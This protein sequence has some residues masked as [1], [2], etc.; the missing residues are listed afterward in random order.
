MQIKCTVS[1]RLPVVT[2]TT[3]GY[4]KVT[5]KNYRIRIDLPGRLLRNLICNCAAFP[6]IHH[7]GAEFQSSSSSDAPSIRAVQCNAASV[8]MAKKPKPRLKDPFVGVWKNNRAPRRK[9][10]FRNYEKD[11]AS[12][13]MFEYFGIDAAA[14]NAKKELSSI[15]VLQEICK[16]GGLP[17]PHYE[18]QVQGNPNKPFHSYSVNF[19]IP[20]IL[21]STYNIRQTHVMG[22]ARYEQKKPAKEQAAENVVMKLERMMKMEQF[23]MPQWLQTFKEQRQ[24]EIEILQA[25]PV[26]QQVPGVA[27]QNV[28]IDLTFQETEPAGRSGRISFHP[29]VIQHPRAFTAA[30]ILT[31]RSTDTLPAIVFKENPTLEGPLQQWANIITDGSLIGVK[32]HWLKESIGIGRVGAEIIALRKAF[33]VNRLNKDLRF[34]GKSGQSSF[35]MAKLFLLWPKY[36]F[37]ALKELLDQV[38]VNSQKNDASIRNGPSGITTRQNKLVTPANDTTTWKTRVDIFRKHQQMLPL[39]IDHVESK[40][41]HEAWVTIVRGGTASG[42]TTR[43]PL[44]LSLFSPTGPSTRVLVAQPRRLACQTAARRV[45]FEQDA[46]LGS[47]HCPVGYAI[48]F[49]SM[50]SKAHGR[51]IDFQTPGVILRKAMDDPLLSD[52]THLCID[53]VHERNADM[54]LLVSLAKETCKKRINHETLPPLRIILMSATLDSSRWESYFRDAFDDSI[55]SVQVLDVPE[56]RRFPVDVVHLDDELFPTDDERVMNMIPQMEQV[57]KQA[58]DSTVGRYD[59]A[60]CHAMAQLATYLVEKKNLDGGSILCFLPGMDEIRLVDKMIQENFKDRQSEMPLVTYLHS[61]LYSTDQLKVFE[62]GSK[63]ILST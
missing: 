47:E 48:R 36:Q 7:G 52:I 27:W 63:I 21:K 20:E 43:Y 50:P 26:T 41:P 35:G 34:P 22:Q 61:S 33:S 11:R 29:E 44:L 24:R 45:A 23:T 58:D 55:E 32:D 12:R 51:T 46:V 18:Y 15:T 25:T 49:A 16:I 30:K 17:T 6:K 2:A 39:P 57:A 3:S 56:I 9:K 1:V 14:E 19:R 31:A 5:G 40:I 4:F 42:K 60:L 59:Q 38:K 10:P 53:E 13:E 37:P 62:P 28:P 8:A 54:D